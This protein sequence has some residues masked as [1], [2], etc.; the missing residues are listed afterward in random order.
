MDS[1][2][3]RAVPVDIQVECNMLI[4]SQIS[5]LGYVGLMTSRSTSP[6][7]RAGK[8]SGVGT[9][10]RVHSG[11]VIEERGEMVQGAIRIPRTEIESFDTVG[12]MDDSD[13]VYAGA[14][15][16]KT[17]NNIYFNLIDRYNSQLYVVGYQVIP[18]VEFLCKPCPDN[19]KKQQSVETFYARKVKQN[20]TDVPVVINRKI[21]KCEPK[22]GKLQLVCALELAKLQQQIA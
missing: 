14:R 12:Y 21:L 4:H 20:D 9:Y 18:C 13:G 1:A 15:I 8:C 5:G 19:C 7:A 3:V 10:R 6:V 22:P 16:F 2:A 11:Q 17:S